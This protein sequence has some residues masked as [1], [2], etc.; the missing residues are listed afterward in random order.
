MKFKINKSAAAVQE[1]SGGSYISKSGIYDVVIDFVS[2]DVTKNGAESVNFNID[3]NGSKSTIYGPYV[4]AGNGDP[5]E[6]GLKLINKIFVIADAP[7][8]EPNIEEETHNV[9]KDNK[10]QDF[11]VF[12][13]LSGLEC[14][15][16]LQ[17][18]YSRYDGNITKRL[19]IKNFYSAEGASAEEYISGTNV[20]KRLEQDSKYADNVTYRDSKKG[21]N[22][23]PTPEEVQAW[24][25]EKAGK[26]PATP[27]TPAAK[28][29]TKP[30]GGLF[31]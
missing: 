27:S 22:D 31:N 5:L 14:K 29:K 13:D 16:R 20:G 2:L 24:K 11:A 19:A 6:I 18:E 26:T 25:D 4:Q 9:G 23:A 3:Y 28:T 15:I 10:A 21:A 12:T 17:E 1:S 8:G 30:A 7:E